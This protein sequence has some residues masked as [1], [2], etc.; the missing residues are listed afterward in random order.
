ML[1]TSPWRREDGQTGAEFLGMLALVALIF[2]AL[3]TVGVPQS[4]AS[5][6]RRAVCTIAS[7]TDC[8]TP[9]PG[10]G[11][12]DDPYPDPGAGERE[13][14]DDEC[15]GDI[16]DDPSRAGDDGAV[17]D[18]QV[19]KAYENLGRV[20][21]YYHDTF[22]WDSYDGK[23]SP[24]VG[25]VDYCDGGGADGVSRWDDNRVLFAPGAGDALDT[26]AH[27]FTHGVTAITAGLDYECQSGALNESL[28][29]I[30]AW[31][32]TPT[33]RRTERTATATARTTRTAAR[34]ATTGTRDASASRGTSTTTSH[35]E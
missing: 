18:D 24:V 6:V 19:D 20:Y 29:D 23:G 34:S 30:M 28:S 17:G 35:S 33:T 13:I 25:V 31:T 22:G 12:A 3:F 1:R 7:G 9:G 15:Q 10:G 4:I 16:P 27:E 21:D 2:A 26:A 8:G 32:S 14:Y 5:G 11:Y